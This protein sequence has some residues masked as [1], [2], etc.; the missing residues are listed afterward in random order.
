MDIGY[1]FLAQCYAGI[2]AT[3][4]Y[5]CKAHFKVFKFCIREKF[6]GRKVLWFSW[7][8]SYSESFTMKYS[9][10]VSNYN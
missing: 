3:L 10:V 9:Y 1:T 5:I 8:Y 4:Y 2:R 7:F 6:R